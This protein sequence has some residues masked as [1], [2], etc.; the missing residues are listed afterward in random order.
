MRRSSFR[1]RL[2]ASRGFRPHLHQSPCVICKSAEAAYLSEQG[3]NSAATQ[4]SSLRKAAASPSLHTT[5]AAPLFSSKHQGEPAAA[6]SLVEQRRDALLQWLQTFTVNGRLRSST[7][8]ADIETVSPPLITNSEEFEACYG[9]YLRSDDAEVEEDRYIALL[10]TLDQ[11]CSRVNVT[12]QTAG[13][14]CDGQRTSSATSS[15][16]RLP[17]RL[18]VP[19]VGTNTAKDT[20]AHLNSSTCTEERAGNVF[21]THVR[22][23]FPSDTAAVAKQL[24]FQD[25][26]LSIEE[27]FHAQG[28]A[29]FLAFGTALGA[30]RSGCFIPYDEDIDLGV[31]YTE[32]CASP[33]EHAGGGT[34]PVSD[35]QRVQDR[36]FQLIDALAATGIF[37]VFDVCGAVEKGL[38]LRLLHTP[39]NTRVDINLFYPPVPGSDDVIV[40]AEGPFL[41][42]SSF[43]EAAGRRAHQMYRYRHQPFDKE[44][45]RLPFCTRTPDADGFWVPPERYL[46]ENYG[47]DWRTPKQYTYAEGLAREFHNIIDE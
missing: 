47:A 18:V 35:L 12:Q 29:F 7:R 13:R 40:Q 9:A 21:E 23:L 27:V 16:I 3:T 24:A 42:A 44:L 19:L 33:P 17:T 43:Y 6:A 38:E 30:R 45:T 15:S 32:L 8:F 46:T 36:L 1:R 10:Q 39:T 20:A 14:P 34:S 26:L 37:L 25:A 2:C 22:R 4:A 31:L 5:T 41:W 11:Q 28:I